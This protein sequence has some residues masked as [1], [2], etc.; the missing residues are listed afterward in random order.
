MSRWIILPGAHVGGGAQARTVPKILEF[1]KSQPLL[2]AADGG[3][4]DAQLAGD[5][6]AGT[7][8]AAQSSTVTC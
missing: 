5:L 4:R 1:V 3:G 8:L 6:L 7:A 2:D